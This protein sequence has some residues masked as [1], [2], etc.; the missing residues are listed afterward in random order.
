MRE[1]IRNF[2]LG[3]TYPYRDQLLQRWH[4]GEFWL[5]IDFSHLHEYDPKLLALLTERP[6]E[7]LPL[8]EEAIR[9]AL[10]K[11]TFDLKDSEREKLP[12]FQLLVRS[13]QVPQQLRAV[14]A[15]HVN[16][17]IKVPGIV[18]S[19]SR[20]QSKAVNI[21][22]KCTK[23]SAKKT[24][25]C[26]SGLQGA[27]LPTQCDQN[28]AV[29]L[30]GQGC[31]PNSYVVMADECSYVDQQNFKLQEA[32]EM[33]P[34]GEMPR[35]LLLSA[36]RS[37]VDRVAPG[38]RVSV[39]GVVS[40][41]N[42]GKSGGGRGGQ[43]VRSM[44]LKVVGLKVE[45]EGAGRERA[46]FTPD[47]EQRFVEM[48][49]DP[50]IYAKLCDSIA[51]SISGDYTNDIKK[52]IACLL[53]GGSRK[54]LPD[55]MRLRG[56]INVLLLGDPSTAK[57]QFL[58]FV[59]KVAP[60]GVYTSGKGSSAAGLTASVTRDARGEYYLE[61]G[62]MV[63]ADGGV[64]CIDEFDKMREQDRV[65]IH[66]A[67]EQQTIS[68]AK[69]GITTVLNSRTSVLAAANPIFGRY[70]DLKSAS[71][72]IDLMSTIL[73]RFDL[74]FIVRDIRD[75]ERDRS[76]ARHVMGVHINAA[77]LSVNGA[78]D[79]LGQGE[80]GGGGRLGAEDGADLDLATMKKFIT[81]CRARC[82]PRL[83]EATATL[84]SSEYVKI[85]TEMRDRKDDQGDDAQAVPIT[86]RQLE[87]LVRVSESLAKM[88]LKPEVS[89]GHVEEAIRLFKVSTGSAASYSTSTMMEFANEKTKQNVERA[90]TFLKH[91]L[92]MHSKVNT[93]RVLE[94]GLYQKYDQAALSKALGIMV[95]K[96]EVKEYN[97]G[98]L[99]ERLR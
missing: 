64:C 29:I 42:S 43:G 85:R 88:Q 58:K 87:A 65:A 97:H 18:I 31:G 10:E 67:M 82:A 69:A 70:D 26:S 16:K 12:D 99:I 62:A 15:D 57:S 68:V 9:E 40:L 21:V 59:E 45:S 84:L 44:Y 61:G 75:E 93:N 60:V 48:A 23:C 3:P 39:L 77:S 5:E 19:A 56:D 2:R 80:A 95:M 27:V 49:N 41:F 71:E 34:T 72:N 74:I 83:S 30:A 86:V 46:L 76:I 35:N 20:I 24:I 78:D 91:R 73:S 52:A 8:F 38:T 94:E 55:G 37:L 14:N 98:R 13:D 92:P 25:A 47:E 1:F 51:P 79:R 6:M 89:A 4:K 11:L 7:Y 22:C 36:D 96:G 32:P 63:L 17:L 33:V 90:E 50:L 28:G 54:V 66:E 81:Y 53:M